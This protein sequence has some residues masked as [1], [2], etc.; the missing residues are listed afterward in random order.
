M[1][2]ADLIIDPHEAS[3]SLPCPYPFHF[4][5]K[6]SFLRLF[7]ALPVLI[8]LLLGFAPE[9][10]LAEKIPRDI[11][12]KITEARVPFI[13]NEGQTDGQVC[14]FTKTVSGG[15]YVTGQGQIV[16]ELPAGKE[17]KTRGWVLVEENLDRL[18]AKEIRGEERS[19]TLVSFFIGDDPAKWKRGLPTYQMV[20]LG[21]VYKGIRLRLLACG[22]SVEKL[23]H[24]S[25]GGDPAAIRVAIHG[26]ESLKVNDRGEL[27]VGTGNGPVVFS[28]PRAFQ[29][30]GNEQEPV[31]ASYDVAGNSYGFKVA[32]Y[33][34]KRELII[35]PLIQ[36]TYL[37]GSLGDSAEAIAVSGGNVYV[38]GY[39]SST[40]FPGTAGGF[41]P[42]LGGKYDAFVAKFDSSLTQLI[43][44]TYLGGSD[45]DFANSVFISEGSIYVAGSTKSANFPGT[46]AGAQPAYKNQA[47][48]FVS[49]FS[50]DLTTAA[51]LQSTYLGGSGNDYATF[52]AVS[53]GYVY[54]GGS[55]ESTDF[56]KTA[57]GAQTV[58]HEYVDGFV[59]KLNGALTS[60]VQSTYLGGNST[61][62]VHSLV[63]A[64]GNVYA[65]GYTL[66]TDFPG[67]AG[68]AQPAIGG[69]MDAF[70]SKLSSDLKQI[71]QSTYVG[72]NGV[73]NAFSVAY[74]GGNL[75]LAGN[76]DSINFPG[77]AE[78]AQPTAGGNGDGFAALL[79]ADLTQIVRSTYLGGTGYDAA[80]Q[81]VLSGTV[82]VAGYTLSENFPGTVDGAQ[83]AYA[84]SGDAFVSKLS[85]DLKQL[86][87]STYLGGDANDW[88]PAI[89][90][91]GGN[92]Y[93]AGNTS[94]DSFPKVAGGAQPARG[95]GTQDAFVSL[96]TTSL[97]GS[98]GKG[99]PWLLLLLGN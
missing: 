32:S 79:N 22:G 94:S 26:A 46:S 17:A 7:V 73:D 67:T 90:V 97:R 66:S 27:E 62:G 84:G 21:E 38:V 98:S 71:L 13:L 41:Q 81:I 47:D 39:T 83:P 89:A 20:N 34:T 44:S 70:A 18:P 40:N 14:F 35:D 93:V 95:G 6:E 36:S 74:Y 76:T 58:R 86:V 64:G 9:T 10:A 59:T 92:V 91:S 68:G 87:Q 48:G 53:E 29:R 65:T 3:P 49:K 1:N 37:G 2:P 88:N 28:R 24:V 4:L 33:D 45:D 30:A 80:G 57:G 19:E 43:Q 82:Y 56:P 63:C 5:V 55:T 60:F 31:E 54:V 75:Y 42:G 12:A 16:Y 50:G 51:T 99:H 96:L 72:G 25:P 15:V 78:G 69:E 23:Y 8:M 11:Q 85:S 52:V 77:T 61:E